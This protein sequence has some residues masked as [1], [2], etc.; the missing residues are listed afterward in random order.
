MVRGQP[1]P[2]CNYVFVPRA[3]RSGVAG[4]T[5]PRSLDPEQLPKVFDPE[6]REG[7]ARVA[8]RSEHT[9]T[10][11]GERN[12]A[13][14]PGQKPNAKPPLELPDCPAQ[15]RL[16]DTEFCRRFG[17]TPFV[18]HCNKSSQVI[19]GFCAAFIAPASSSLRIIAANPALADPPSGGRWH[20]EARHA[21]L[22]G[23]RR[24]WG[25]GNQAR[26]GAAFDQ[27]GPANYFT[28]QVHID[29]LFNP[30]AWKRPA[31]QRVTAA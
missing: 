27:R 15:R 25:D 14:R 19:Q 18:R 12:T 2:Y 31:C 8:V 13:R 16:R 29:P 28:G 22:A 24:R 17:E 23:E 10:S 7:D 21:L 5:H 26:W 11:L 4:A 6:R 3:P 9:F 1:R 20:Q 30:G